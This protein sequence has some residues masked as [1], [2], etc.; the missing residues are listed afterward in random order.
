MIV[1]EVKQVSTVHSTRLMDIQRD[2]IAIY[3]LVSR[4][5]VERK[6]DAARLRTDCAFSV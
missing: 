2:H 3:D 6:T 5:T 1:F 4:P